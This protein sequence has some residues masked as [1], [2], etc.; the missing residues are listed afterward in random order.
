MQARAIDCRRYL[1]QLIPMPSAI[2]ALATCGLHFDYRLP[3]A[4][5]THAA[6]PTAV[7]A[8]ET[9]AVYIDIPRAR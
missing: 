8:R 1:L 5:D 6:Q 4:R 9:A 7:L 3:A 2:L